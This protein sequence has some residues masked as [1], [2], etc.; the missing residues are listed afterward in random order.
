MRMVIFILAILAMV[1]I[2]LFWKEL[3]KPGAVKDLESRDRS[4]RRDK[5]GAAQS[6]A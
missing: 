2:G 4:G 5:N 6:E 1:A 3:A